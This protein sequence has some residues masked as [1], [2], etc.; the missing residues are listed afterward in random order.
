MIAF[1]KDM[2]P[3]FQSVALFITVTYFNK[4]RRLIVYQSNKRLCKI[5][6]EHDGKRFA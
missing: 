5:T 2:R 1:F 6:L 3:G 4:E